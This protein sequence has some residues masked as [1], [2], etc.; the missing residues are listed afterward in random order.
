MVMD[1]PYH[2][3]QVMKDQGVMAIMLTINVSDLYINTEIFGRAF[4]TRV[5]LDSYQRL[6]Y[7]V[8]S[9]CNLVT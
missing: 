7:M 6:R 8:E 5:L 3:T 1:E 4:L 2:G 9:L